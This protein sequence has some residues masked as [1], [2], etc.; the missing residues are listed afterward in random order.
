MTRKRARFWRWERAATFVLL[1][2]AMTAAFLVYCRWSKLRLRVPAA[3]WLDYFLVA[4]ADLGLLLCLQT[5]WLLT[6][7]S[8]WAGRFRSWAGLCLFSHLPIYVVSVTGERYFSETQ[9]I[10][11]ARMLSYM[12]ENFASSA[13]V[14]T[15]GLDA[16]FL[17]LVG[18]VVLIYATMLAVAC[19][20]CALPRSGHIGVPAGALLIGLGGLFAP[21][22]RLT[23]ARALDGNFASDLLPNPVRAQELARSVPRWLRYQ[24]PSIDLARFDADLPR[25]D[26]LLVLLESTRRDLF[27][28]YGGDASLSPNLNE[29]LR[30][31]AVVDDAYLGLSHTTKELVTIHCGMLPTFGMHLPESQPGGLRMP[32]L[33][34]L[35]RR[36]GYESAFYQSA[37]NFERRSILLMNLGYESAFI[38]RRDTAEPSKLRGYLGFDESVLLQPLRQ[39]FESARSGPRLTTVLSVSTHHPYLFERSLPRDPT[40]VRNSYDAAARFV[41]ETL[42]RLLLDMKQSGSLENT[43]V[44]VTGDHGEAFGERPGFLQHDIVPYEEVTHVPL[45]M[46][47]PGVPE[48]IRVGGLR[49]HWDLLPTLLRL[50]EL[51]VRGVLPGRDL[52]DPVGHAFV[53]SSCWYEASCLSLR[54]G[55]NSFVYF[56][57]AQPME[58]YDLSQD[59]EQ[60]H[61]I[62]SRVPLSVRRRV[63]DRLLDAHH[64]SWDVYDEGRVSHALRM[65]RSL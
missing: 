45:F 25:P 28:A 1:Q 31:A 24:A 64:F 11:T 5:C 39:R 51:P 8:A 34:S 63:R 55:E 54:Q 46:M 18:V 58:A 52:F 44:V 56:Y 26:I 43:I 49:H 10:Q 29:F 3:D 15:A 27:A 20:R 50:V 42:G 41:D 6:V 40:S 32:C 13:Q 16:Y 37:G 60:Q 59:P 35:L 62:I 61:D 33:P 17:T 12:A 23:A 48:G 22:P 36:I 57:G 21:T 38:A 7:R 53:V 30:E 9:Q 4:A 65:P 47:G 19:A 14:L 2:T